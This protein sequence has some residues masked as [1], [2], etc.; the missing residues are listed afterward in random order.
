MV[1]SADKRAVVSMGLQT[2]VSPMGAANFSI[3]I[4]VVPGIHGL[5]PQLSIAYSSQSGKG[6]LGMG[7]SLTGM[8]SI[9]RS[10]RD[11][12]HDGQ[13]HELTYDWNDAFSLDGKRMVLV[14]GTAGEEGAVYHL[15]SDPYSQI[16]LKH[17]DDGTLYF[18]VT[19]QQNMHYR[20]GYSA[21]SRQNLTVNGKD[22]VCT[23]GMD[24]ADDA[25]HNF[26]TYHYMHDG[27]LLYL[28]HIEYGGNENGKGEALNEVV[29]SGFSS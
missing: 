14:S 3:P 10:T 7:C 17:G 8:S 19:M 20:Y 26:M 22:V 1:S 29:C 24:Y 28:D 18:D 11:V 25:Y 5:Q 16:V 4:E 23:W 6:A 15:E 12:A 27:K 21:N 2:G 13:A 9:T